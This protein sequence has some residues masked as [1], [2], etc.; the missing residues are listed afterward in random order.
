MEIIDMAI[1]P[2]IL[3]GFSVITTIPYVAD[4]CTIGRIVNVFWRI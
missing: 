2:D 4:I 1:I 3:V